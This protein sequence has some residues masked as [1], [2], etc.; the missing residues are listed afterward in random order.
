M[1]KL[2]IKFSKEGAIRYISHLDLMRTMERALRRANLQLAFSEGFNPHPKISFASALSLGVESQGE[3]LDVELEKPT[4]IADL[5]DRLNGCLPGGIRVLEIEELKDKAPAAMSL[6]EGAAYQISGQTTPE[7]SKEKWLEAIGGL[8]AQKEVQVEREGKKGLREVDIAPLILDLELQDLV[9]REFTLNVL[10]RSG[11][12][13]NVRAEEVLQALQKY[14]TLPL[15]EET[16]RVRRTGL[17]KEDKGQLVPLIAL[18]NE[19]VK[20]KELR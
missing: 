18:G 3:Y 6:V 10:V 1:Q 19:V 4:A 20:L 8:L 14:Y 2:R 17:Y 9:Q 12:R 15:A 5:K 16:V 11:S 7:W 13:G